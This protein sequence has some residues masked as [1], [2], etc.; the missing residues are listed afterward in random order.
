MPGSGAGPSAGGPA[1]GGGAP[2]SYAS[3]SPY[4]GPPPSGHA[5][6][7]SPHPTGKT[8]GLE[9]V[10]PGKYFSRLLSL[11]GASPAGGK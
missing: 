2:S 4:G 9:K 5:G 8:S 3:T 10:S 7:R 11:D 6:G 1:Y